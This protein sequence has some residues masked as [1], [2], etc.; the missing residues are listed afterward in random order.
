MSAF[1]TNTSQLILPLLG[2]IY[3]RRAGDFTW[4]VIAVIGNYHSGLY[5]VLPLSATAMPENSYCLIAKW[6]MGL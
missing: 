6:A 3:S 5:F 4:E 1:F 2:G